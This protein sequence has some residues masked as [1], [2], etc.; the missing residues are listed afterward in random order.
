MRQLEPLI[1]ECTQLFTDAMYSLSLSA[2]NKNNQQPIDFGQW[3]QWYTF[4][5]IGKISFNRLLG[6]MQ[7]REDS[8]GTIAALDGFARYSS[9]VGQLPELHRCLLGNVTLQR[10]M[11]SV[12][13][14]AKMNAFGKTEEVCFVSTFFFL[15]GSFSVVWM[16]AL[17]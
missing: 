14:L 16:K 17:G 4:D 5:S 10:F 8:R 2:D 1:N 9:A 7:N 11:G 15:S 6:F 3:L 12:P 13:A